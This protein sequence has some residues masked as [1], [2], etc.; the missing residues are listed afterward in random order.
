MNEYE[1]NAEANNLNMN[2]INAETK[3]EEK[4][5]ELNSEVKEEDQE[6]ETCEKSVK[7]VINGCENPALELEEK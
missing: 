1:V 4:D 5:D 7:D 3:T 2:I 6:K